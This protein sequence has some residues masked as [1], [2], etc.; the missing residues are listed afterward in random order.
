MISCILLA[1]GLSSRFGSPKALAIIN[2]KPLIEHLQARLIKTNLGEIII[3]LGAHAE[4]IKPHLFNHKKI[5]FVYNKDY[6]FGQTSSLKIGLKNISSGSQG[7]M[8]LPVDYPV[9]QAVT[10]DQLLETFLKDAPLILMPTFENKKG[11]PPIFDIALKQ[12]FLSLEDTTGLNTIA[13]RHEKDVQS[14]YVAD[15]GIVMSFNT[16]EEFE[17]IKAKII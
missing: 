5:R 8:L 10:I 7:F 12:E 2:Q 17:I 9:I 3:V 4:L 6:N 14:I 1:A 11:H 13:R 16:T 15:E